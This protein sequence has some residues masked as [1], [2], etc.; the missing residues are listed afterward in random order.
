MGEETFDFQEVDDMSSTSES[1]E[2][3]NKESKKTRRG[4]A[5]RGT[6]RTEILGMEGEIRE[7]EGGRERKKFKPTNVNFLDLE[8]KPKSYKNAGIRKD[9][10]SKKSKENIDPLASGGLDDKDA[11]STHPDFPQAKARTQAQ[12]QNQIPLPR[13]ND[14]KRDHS[15]INDEEARG[16]R[17]P[18]KT[19][20]E[21]TKTKIVKAKAHLQAADNAG[22]GLAEFVNDHC[23]TRVFLLSL[24]HALYVSRKPFKHFTP[25]SP[26]F[27]ATLQKVF[28]R[29][30]TNVDY[31]LSLDDKVTKTA[32][33]R[34]KARKSRLAIDILDS[35]KKFFKQAE[36]TDKPQAVH[37]YVYW[38]LRPGGPAYYSKPILREENGSE[39]EKA[40]EKDDANKITPSGFL[41]SPFIAPIAKHYLSFAANSILNP[42]ISRKHPPKGLYALILTAVERAFVAHVKGTYVDPRQ[43]NYDN[44]WKAMV[45]FFG[46]IDKVKEEQW[47]SIL[48]FSGVDQETGSKQDDNVLCADQ[49]TIS[50]FCAGIYI[51]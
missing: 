26:E 43:F 3:A 29:T 44:T 2:L 47:K 6:L 45:D 49:S 32:Y 28:N 51:D 11:L 5:P 20:S 34:I 30:F 13:T 39:K 31:A 15:R 27:V 24:N 7:Q 10:E 21:G 16:E 18:A 9:F 37:E 42:P 1:G 4:K 19:K 23:W 46:S 25:D 17:A 12:N 48:L 8:S 40:K 36:F 38:A 14:L 50:T 35:V 33:S 22:Q 41:E